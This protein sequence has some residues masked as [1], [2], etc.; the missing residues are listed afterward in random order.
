MNYYLKITLLGFITVNY[1]N[2]QLKIANCEK[3]FPIIE[4]LYALRNETM[5][6]SRNVHTVRYGT[7]T[8]SVFAPRIWSR[9]PRSYEECSSV[10]EFKA[11]VKF[12]YPE[13]CA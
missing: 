1:K 2:L 7:E 5:F 13:N 4:N 3:L 11:K 8:A 12:C 10:N 6:K 9:I